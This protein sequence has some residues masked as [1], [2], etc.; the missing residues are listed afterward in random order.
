MRPWIGSDEVAFGKK[1]D[2]WY[3][4]LLVLAGFLIS[5]YYVW[6]DFQY[7]SNF[8]I[9]ERFDEVALY[10]F[11]FLVYVAVLFFISAW[12]VVEWLASYLLA[13]ASNSQQSRTKKIKS[14]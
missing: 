3:K 7:Q 14:R 13:R 1:T 4:P 11:P 8:S 6:F 5:A 10:L 9:E 2:P 12:I